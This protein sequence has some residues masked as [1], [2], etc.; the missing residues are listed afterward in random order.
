MA[1][2]RH[3]GIS[4]GKGVHTTGL[5]GI[6]PGSEELVLNNLFGVLKAEYQSEFS[7]KGNW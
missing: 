7:H 1:D 3:Y 5:S 4:A 6:S 2:I